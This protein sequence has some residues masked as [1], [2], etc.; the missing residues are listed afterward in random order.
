MYSNRVSATDAMDVLP[1]TVDFPPSTYPTL[2]GQRGKDAKVFSQENRCT[3]TAA[4]KKLVQ[5][6]V[7]LPESPEPGAMGKTVSGGRLCLPAPPRGRKVRFWLQT[8]A[9]AQST[10][11][12]DAELNETLNESIKRSTRRKNSYV[13]TPVA[14]IRLGSLADYAE[15]G[16]TTLEDVDA[17]WASAQEF[18]PSRTRSRIFVKMHAGEVVALDTDLTQSIALLKRQLKSMYRAEFGAGSDGCTLRFRGK[19]LPE[20]LTL[21]QCR[22]ELG[23]VVH[24][25]R[26]E[27]RA[28]LGTG[29]KAFRQR[30]YQ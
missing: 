28:P 4:K 19:H 6:S 17:K 21:K 10:E 15:S 27:I 14:P 25:S 22:V 18:V 23:S 5:L 24:A 26:T 3:P 30:A 29:A 2:L 7:T 11:L 8:P 12:D 13:K 9:N 1:G 16:V 20:H